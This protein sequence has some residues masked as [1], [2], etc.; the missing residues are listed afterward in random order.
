MHVYNYSSK[1]SW[2]K[3]NE[4]K[5][6]HKW[7]KNVTEE[8]WQ[9]F[10]FNC[11]SDA[12][13]QMMITDTSV[14]MLCWR[15]C[16]GP[17]HRGLHKARGQCSLHTI[18]NFCHWRPISALEVHTISC[19]VPYKDNSLDLLGRRGWQPPVQYV[20]DLIWNNKRHGEVHNISWC[21]VGLDPMDGLVA[22]QQL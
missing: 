14:K 22:C 18:H 6:I 13:L 3:V 4:L 16:C 7:Y 15:P 20:V 12:T 8:V 5:R 9:I 11:E 10:I 17:R 2:S 21:T 1:S 19:K